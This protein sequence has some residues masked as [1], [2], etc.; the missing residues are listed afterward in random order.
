[1]PDGLVIT[2]QEHLE[3]H[4]V[5]F[6]QDL[7]T[8]QQNLHPDGVLQYVQAK[9]TD[10]MNTCLCRPFIAEKVETSLFMMGRTKHQV[11]MAIQWGFQ[12]H[13]DLLGPS[14]TNADSSNKNTAKL[15]PPF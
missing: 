9:V 10:E 8:A 6:Y 14:V 2:K 3:Q 1:L 7:F 11:R 4:A 5:S 13:W 12:T 15:L